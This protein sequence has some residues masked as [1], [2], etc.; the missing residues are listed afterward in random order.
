ME[1]EERREINRIPRDMRVDLDF[2]EFDWEEMEPPE[3]ITG[4]DRE[5]LSLLG[6]TAIILTPAV[7]AKNIDRSRSSVSRR[8]STLEAG[9]MVEK[10]ER[11]HYQISNEGYA[12]MTQR[13]PTEP[14]EDQE[15][16]SILTKILTSE[17][18]EELD[19]EGKLS[20]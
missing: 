15:G 18:L 11:G 6:N 5:I 10:T 1:D 7:I 16:N 12:R 17:E 14:P 20:L 8:L 9:D 19:R 4:L 13:F 3:W 2:A